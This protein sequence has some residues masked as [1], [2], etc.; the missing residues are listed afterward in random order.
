V[1]ACTLGVASCTPSTATPFFCS[2]YA[3]GAELHVLP[4][5]LH[6]NCAWLRVRLVGLLIPFLHLHLLDRVASVPAEAVFDARLGL[7][8]CTPCMATQNSIL[9]SASSSHAAC[10]PT[11]AA[12]KAGLFARTPLMAA[13][14]FSP[15]HV[16]LH[17][18]GRATCVP[19]GCTLLDVRRLNVCTLT[20]SV[21]CASKF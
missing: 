9:A 7:P 4:L 15:S 2:T 17:V 3:F 14:L 6:L 10:A 19:T 8:A 13:R 20:P 12:C 18:R 16:W 21:F 11:D 1:V 5:R